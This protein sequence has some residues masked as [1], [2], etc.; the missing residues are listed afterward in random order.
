VRNWGRHLQSCTAKE[1]GRRVGIHLWI[2]T[3]GQWK[4]TLEQDT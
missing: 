1:M 4:L 3:Y 2:R